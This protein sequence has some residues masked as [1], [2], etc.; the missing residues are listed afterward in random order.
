MKISY[1]ITCCNEFK[2]IKRLLEQLSKNKKEEDE[3][4]VLLDEPKSTE[5][6]KEYLREYKNIYIQEG[7]FENDFS[8]WKNQL[9][10]LCN[11]DFIFQLDADEYLA[12][13]MCEN[14]ILILQANP[15]VDLYYVPRINTVEGITEEYIQKWGWKYENG[16]INWPD[17]QSRIYRNS[18]DVK[19]KNKVHEVIEGYKQFT[20]LPA[21]DELAL[22]HPKTIEKQEIQNNFYNTL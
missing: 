14:I 2:E 21:V 5:E 4:V 13:S 19:W 16:R 12:D 8:K 11:G 7:K 3:I 1:A 20:F 22:I 18:P 6:L 15:E 9:N 17:Y 10:S